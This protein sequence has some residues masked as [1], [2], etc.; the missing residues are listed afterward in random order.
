MA[1]GT[2]FLCATPIGNLEDIT[3]R[4][5]RVLKE[6]DLVAC[7]NRGRT[8][9]L[10]S[11]F[12]IRKSLISYRE[13]GHEEL[14]P[15]ILSA[16]RE[17]KKV[18]L[19]SDAG[20]PGVADPG[21]SLVAQA[22]REGLAVEV[23]PG[24]SSL[25]AALAL[26]GYPADSFLFLGFLP[27]KTRKRRE[28][29]EALAA[30]CRTA[31]IFEAPHRIV[32][33]LGEL[34]GIIPDREAFLG[35]E[36]TKKFE[37]RLWGTPAELGALM[38]GRVVKGEITLVIKG[39]AAPRQGESSSSSEALMAPEEYLAGLMREGVTL[40]EARDLVARRFGLSRRSVYEKGLQLRSK[41]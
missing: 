31:V 22:R 13:E 1:P 40:R 12:G 35:R 30:E 18:A 4:A 20:M 14:A 37:E 7:E 10:L 5:L 36:L 27:R 32:K 15:A 38:A 33:M 17:G 16:L 6:A 21:P 24:P 3:L 26:S 2:L 19:V 9:G 29:L 41:K 11:H 39:G 23:I 25:L 8:L 34:A 28:V